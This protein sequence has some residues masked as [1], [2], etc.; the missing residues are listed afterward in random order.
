MDVGLWIAILLVCVGCAGCR[1]AVTVPVSIIS[2]PSDAIRHESLNHRFA[3]TGTVVD[4]DGHALEGV[5][6]H[7][8]SV[9]PENVV[10]TE[11][12]T[13]DRAFSFDR[14]GRE[15]LLWFTKNGYR[16]AKLSLVPEATELALH[17]ST[18]GNGTGIRL[19]PISHL[20]YDTVDAEFHVGQEQKLLKVVLPRHTEGKLRTITAELLTPWTP[21]PFSFTRDMLPPGKWTPSVEGEDNPIL[22]L[23]AL[24]QQNCLSGVP[25]LAAHGVQRLEDMPISPL[26]PFY[27][28][29]SMMDLNAYKT[30]PVPGQSYFFFARIGL[31][32][33]RGMVTLQTA[34][35]ANQRASLVLQIQED[36]SRE[37]GADPVDL[38]RGD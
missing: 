11:E 10:E 13:V 27:D 12:R 3:M 20:D 15:I 32:Y 33:A 16:D 29:A 14:H 30:R 2:T 6:V 34:D 19:R 35:A 7:I 18:S 26:L 21:P 31:C 5:I 36:G 22:A 25:L 4:Q 1:A 24:D 38:A 28:A 9:T 37:F 23:M 8:C 17:T